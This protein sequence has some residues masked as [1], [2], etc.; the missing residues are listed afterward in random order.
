MNH[1]KPDDL[2]T[3][4][5]ELKAGLEDGVNRMTDRVKN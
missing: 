1:Y 4:D 5:P 2:D 3:M